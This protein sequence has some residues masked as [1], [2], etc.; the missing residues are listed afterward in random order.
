MVSPQSDDNM[1]FCIEAAIQ[2]IS[3][4]FMTATLPT[5][6]A[7]RNYPELPGEPCHQRERMRLKYSSSAVDRFTSQELLAYAMSRDDPTLVAQALSNGA[8]YVRNPDMGFTCFHWAVFMN[9]IKVVGFFADHAPDINIKTGSGLTPL[10]IAALCGYTGCVD[11]LMSRGADLY[12]MNNKNS[13]PLA[14]AAGA[15]KIETVLHFLNDPRIIQ[16]QPELELQL[17][18]KE[19]ALFNAAIINNHVGMVKILLNFPA[20]ISYAMD[21]KRTIL[22]KAAGH[23]AMVT[24]LHQTIFVEGNGIQYKGKS[25]R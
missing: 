25:F 16:A 3:Q 7:T 15:G 23:D 5:L 10:H 1:K 18:S 24:L 11:V 6:N 12:A 8:Q 20:I 9:N 22:E 2:E 14:L 4:Y 19:N 17:A 13:T 21:N